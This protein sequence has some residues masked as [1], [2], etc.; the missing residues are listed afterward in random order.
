MFVFICSHET[1]EAAEEKKPKTRVA[2][3]TLLVVVSHGALPCT[4]LFV[5]FLGMWR[6]C[7]ERTRLIAWFQILEAFVDMIFEF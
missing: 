1:Q 4:C 2:V 3:F 6:N 5:I 7:K